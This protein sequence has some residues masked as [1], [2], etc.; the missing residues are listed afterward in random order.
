MKYLPA[1]LLSLLL[2]GCGVSQHGIRGY[3]T[4]VNIKG[5]T[6]S[7]L[8]GAINADI[9]GARK[10]DV[11]G[12]HIDIDPSVTYTKTHY[13]SAGQIVATSTLPGG[14]YVSEVTLA[15]GEADS[16]RTTAGGNTALKALFG[17]A[18][19]GLGSDAFGW[20]SSWLAPK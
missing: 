7:V 12:V 17:F 16:K 8:A 5:E 18:L 20:L 9:P 15:Q 19:P 6:K 14:V 13:N 2:V 1:I 4:G 11:G 3:D 10:V